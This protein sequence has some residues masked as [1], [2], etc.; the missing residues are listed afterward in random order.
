MSDTPAVQLI[1]AETAETTVTKR[2]SERV[3]ALRSQRQWSARELA[4]AC[5]NEGMP[6][7]SRGAIA[8]IETGAR[9]SVTADEIA[10]LARALGVTTETL[11]S[12]DMGPEAEWSRESG[13]AI[14]RPEDAGPDAPF[15][16]GDIVVLLR[17]ISRIFSTEERALAFLRSIRYPRE[18]IPTWGDGSTA[19][20]FWAL[21]FDDLDRG[22][23]AEP[24]QR[25]L[26]VAMAVYSTNSVLS[27]LARKY[28][29]NAVVGVANSSSTN[30]LPPSG[31][32]QEPTC[33]LVAWVD[34]NKRADLSAWLA[35]HG[36]DPQPAWLT[37]T[38]TSFQVNETDSHAL[39]QLMRTRD[40]IP[41][42]V[43]P[44]GSP[45]YVIR[46][47]HVQGPDGRSFR[48]NDVP[49]S[50]PVGSVADEL[51]AQYSNGLPGGEQPTVVEHVG[52]SGQPRMNPDNTL[53]EEGVTEG[54][55]LQV[56]FERRAVGD[57]NPFHQIAPQERFPAD[58]RIA[59]ASATP[60]GVRLAERKPH[61]FLTVVQLTSGDASAALELHLGYYV[62]YWRAKMGPDEFVRA[63]QKSEGR[64][65]SLF[66]LA[67]DSGEVEQLQPKEVISIVTEGAARSHPRS[68]MIRVTGKD[69]SWVWQSGP[70]DMVGITDAHQWGTYIVYASTANHR[71]NFRTANAFFA[72]SA[73]DGRKLARS[74]H[75]LEGYLNHWM[76]D[77]GAELDPSS[78]QSISS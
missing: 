69:H 14:H 61:P 70:L 54:S 55:Q 62:Y 75:L 7:L 5:A 68:A 26:R 42:V 31:S 20:D 57:F 8:K 28:S 32:T 16:Q 35:D 33:H 74:T 36:L 23:M 13:P 76:Q 50:T 19:L 3:R 46:H 39:D 29:A 30:S 10:V 17:E 67:W 11:M 38:S 4:E 77:T 25:L 43:V 63:I 34:D 66:T 49:S 24:Y 60:L 27:E 59:G 18:L 2:V 22:V 47:L 53:A 64:P 72:N 21:I 40:D 41:W 71:A 58:Q 65:D 56:G 45:D 51:V 1:S 52:N 12:E 15:T 37:P 78:R 9:K 48:F 73:I 6:S 44:P